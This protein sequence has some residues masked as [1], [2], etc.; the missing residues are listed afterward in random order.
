MMRVALGDSFVVITTDPGEKHTG[1]T[2]EEVNVPKKTFQ[3]LHA[4]E[5]NGLEESADYLEH[6]MHFY[7]CR[8]WV[9]EGFRLYADKA[10]AKT[11]SEFPEI[12]TIGA[13]QYVALK[14]RQSLHVHKQYASQIKVPNFSDATMKKVGVPLTMMPSGHTRDAFRHFVCYWTHTLKMPYPKMRGIYGSPLTSDM[15]HLLR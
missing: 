1:V 11:Y 4:G 7:K 14:H 6:A 9:Y 12:E 13:M 15:F 2:I 8:L 3:L 10:N 5:V